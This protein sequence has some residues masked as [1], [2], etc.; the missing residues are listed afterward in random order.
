MILEDMDIDYLLNAQI[1]MLFGGE[2][3]RGA[4]DQTLIN[5]L[6]LLLIDEPTLDLDEETVRG[7]IKYFQKI[8]S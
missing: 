1:D 2:L 4:L 8:N 6:D 7:M 3:K 5:Q